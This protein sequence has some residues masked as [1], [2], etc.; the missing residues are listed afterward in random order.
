MHA[1]RQA[2]QARQGPTD[3]ARVEA[4]LLQRL[5]LGDGGHV[6]IPYARVGQVQAPEAG[7]GVRGEAADAWYVWCGMREKVLSRHRQSASAHGYR[8]SVRTV[9][10]GEVQSLQAGREV[11]NARVRDARAGPEGELAE[12]G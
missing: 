5:Q 2:R 6:P 1:G 10:L 4:Q 8:P 9:A 12:L 3:V 11:G 7:E